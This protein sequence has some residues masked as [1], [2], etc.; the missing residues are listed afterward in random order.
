MLVVVNRFKSD[1]KLWEPGQEYSGA[2]GA[3]LLARGLVKE[4]GAKPSA[5]KHE[6][7]VESDFEEPKSE[8]KKGKK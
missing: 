8:K 2:F 3:D 1:K 7:K 4:E 6:P 5:P